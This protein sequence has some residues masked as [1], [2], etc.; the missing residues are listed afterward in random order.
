MER[1]R[2]TID[3]EAFH[4]LENLIRDIKREAR[5][6]VLTKSRDPRAAGKKILG[7]AEGADAE[8]MNL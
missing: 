1:V 6:L 7:L 2:V 5:D 8:L 4:K 3:L